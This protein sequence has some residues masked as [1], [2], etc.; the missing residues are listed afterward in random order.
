MS[1]LVVYS[2]T[3]FYKEA[4]IFFNIS[5]TIDILG[6]GIVPA[7]FDCYQVTR[8]IKTLAIRMQQ[9][10]KNSLAVAKFLEKHQKVDKV[11]HP[12]LPSHPQYEL[13]KKQASGWSGMMSFY[14]KGGLQ[15]SQKFLKELKVVQL[16]TSLG[17]VESLAGLP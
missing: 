16:A 12:G 13:L 7:P 5:S 3:N 9:H 14:I 4:L 15:E 8:S 1:D 6:L 10:M 11:L 17:G 2:L